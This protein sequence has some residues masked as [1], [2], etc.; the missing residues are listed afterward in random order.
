MAPQSIAVQASGQVYGH[1][2]SDPASGER[3]RACH[4][5]ESRHSKAAH[6]AKVMH[7]GV[8]QLR[9]RRLFGDDRIRAAATPLETGSAPV[10]GSA[11]PAIDQ[12]GARST[13]DDDEKTT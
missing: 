13:P 5:V 3:E 6:P 4:Q 12:A 1:H 8:W 7:I 11:P 10:P 2:F 9:C